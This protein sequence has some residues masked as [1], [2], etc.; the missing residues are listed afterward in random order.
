MTV[1]SRVRGTRPERVFPHSESHFIVMA[2]LMFILVVHAVTLLQKTSR[3]HSHPLSLINDLDDYPLITR[4]SISV[5][6]IR[7]LT[8][9]H[10]QSDWTE[11]LTPATGP[12]RS[13]PSDAF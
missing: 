13:F 4:V 1:V 5:T 11:M 2:I 6:S 8:A 9:S 10:Y 3:Q 12:C 7:E